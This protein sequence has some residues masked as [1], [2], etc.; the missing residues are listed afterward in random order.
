VT[1]RSCAF[2][3]PKALGFP[4]K[5]QSQGVQCGV[6]RLNSKRRLQLAAQRRGSRRR[7]TSNLGKWH[8]GGA[9]FLPLDQVLKV[10][11][12]ERALWWRAFSGGLPLYRDKISFSVPKDASVAITKVELPPGKEERS[13]FRRN[14]VFMCAA[15]RWCTGSQTGRQGIAVDAKHRMQRED[16]AILGQKRFDLVLAGWQLGGTRRVCTRE[17]APDGD[18]RPPPCQFHRWWGRYQRRAPPHRSNLQVRLPWP[19]H[20]DSSGWFAA[21]LLH[22]CSQRFPSCQGSSSGRSD[23]RVRWAVLIYAGSG[24]LQRMLRRAWRRVC[25]GRSINAAE[26]RVPSAFAALFVLLSLSMF[27]F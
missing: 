16:C 6:L 11:G 5:A 19:I 18:R 9:G 3:A 13:E 25:P 24:W 21:A 27:G 23:H 10:V 2:T 14:D 26:P 12:I 15:R 8:R 20:G 22:V 4:L 7:G 17:P 1:W